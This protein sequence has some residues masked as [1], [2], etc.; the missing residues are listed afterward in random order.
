MARPEF[1]TPSGGPPHDELEALFDADE[2]IL[3]TIRDSRDTASNNTHEPF[4]ESTG[5][6]R[7]SE[8]LG[9]DEEVTITKKRQPVAKLDA[10]R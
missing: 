1:I 5:N 9:I 7:R 8:A 6:V 4:R 2:D 10:T 3:D